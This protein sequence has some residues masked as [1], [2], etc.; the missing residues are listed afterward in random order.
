MLG[1]VALLSLSSK[2][3]LLKSA[4]ERRKLANMPEELAACAKSIG[5]RNKGFAKREFV[6]SCLYCAF[7]VVHAMCTAQR[8]MNKGKFDGQFGA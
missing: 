4:K 8:N 7:S 5:N 3:S 2:S 1:K 6:T